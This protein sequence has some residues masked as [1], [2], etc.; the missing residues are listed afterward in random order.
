MT[1]RRT[2]AERVVAERCRFLL[3][4]SLFP[5]LTCM[6]GPSAKDAARSKFKHTQRHSGSGRGGGRGRGDAGP[7]ASSDAEQPSLAANAWRYDEGEEDAAESD[8]GGAEAGDAPPEPAT[9]LTELFA[10]AT[11]GSLLG[12]RQLRA[13]FEGGWSDGVADDAATGPADVAS[14]LA[15]SAAG[16][17]RLLDGG[18]SITPLAALLDVGSERVAC[19]AGDEYAEQVARHEERVVSRVAATAPSVVAPS[20]NLAQRSGG[21]KAQPPPPPQR[22]PQPVL[23]PLPPPPAVAAAVAP[24]RVAPQPSVVAP[25]AASVVSRPALHAPTP[26]PAPPPVPAAAVD[27]DDAFLDEL[28]G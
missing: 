20:V 5:C 18:A 1:T 15:W 27:D 8:G 6:D 14:L 28:L 16:L 25:R 10:A 11:S 21:A 4:D 3:S 9:D 19:G 23:Q 13:A 26:P 7:S 12:G 2:G 24:P 17:Q 22:P